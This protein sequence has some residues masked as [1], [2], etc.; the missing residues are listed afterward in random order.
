MILS[1]IHIRLA[2]I[3]LTSV[4]SMLYTFSGLLSFP[5]PN[6]KKI[7]EL[8]FLF[9]LTSAS[10]LNKIKKSLTQVKL[11]ELVYWGVEDMKT[12]R[13]ENMENIVWWK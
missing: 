3:S 8:E 12:G 5:V 1:K 13:E 6:L 10:L 4:L 11:R 2:P 7:L 9:Y